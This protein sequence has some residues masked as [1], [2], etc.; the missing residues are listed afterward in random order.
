MTKSTTIKSLSL[1]CSCILGAASTDLGNFDVSLW[2][3]APTVWPLAADFV[4]YIV[5]R[6]ADGVS[7]NKVLATIV[8]AP[9]A[10]N[11]IP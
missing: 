2:S 7:T 4:D 3:V 6:H 10:A 8:A 11:D 5:D 9:S 1:R